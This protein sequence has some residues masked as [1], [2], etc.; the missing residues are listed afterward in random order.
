MT[1]PLAQLL[2]DPRRAITETTVVCLICGGVF[3]QLTNTHLRGH[4]T[5]AAAYK[6]RFGYNAGR[7]LMCEALARHYAERAV[8]VGLAARIARRL[9]VIDP[10][11]RRRGGRR[12]I[13]LEESLN[14]R[15]AQR[16]ARRRDQL[17]GVAL[18]TPR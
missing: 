7:P 17:D 10:S 4:A 11:L 15:D 3:R 9:I 14:R 13:T 1:P 5:T 16:R 8:R 2:A 12:P 18:P 6:A